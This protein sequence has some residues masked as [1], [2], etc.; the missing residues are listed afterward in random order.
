[1]YEHGKWGIS[2]NTSPIMALLVPYYPIELSNMHKLQFLGD[3]IGRRL[4]KGER[5]KLSKKEDNF[6]WTQ[7][8]LEIYG[9]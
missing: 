2:V 5:T 1:M 9:T 6:F 7:T 4:L 8:R 3:V